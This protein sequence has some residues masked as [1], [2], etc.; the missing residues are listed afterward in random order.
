MGADVQPI[1]APPSPGLAALTRGY[2][3][4]PAPRAGTARNS[5]RPYLYASY[6]LP[7]TAAATFSFRI[8]SVPS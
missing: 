8:S 5:S 3:P 2:T 1:G 4:P 6:S 7:S